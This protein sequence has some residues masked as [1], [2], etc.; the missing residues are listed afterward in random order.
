MGDGRRDPK[1]G[2]GK[3]PKR[4]ES[5]IK[6]IQQMANKKEKKK[7]KKKEDLKKKTSAKK[8]VSQTIQQA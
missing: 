7:K 3:G 5:N 2:Q 6:H 4:T 8:Q 1:K